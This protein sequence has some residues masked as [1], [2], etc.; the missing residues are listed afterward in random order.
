MR[1]AR[2]PPGAKQMITPGA[3]S[4]EG[5]RMFRGFGRWIA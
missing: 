4:S 2:M 1:A 3:S 5:A